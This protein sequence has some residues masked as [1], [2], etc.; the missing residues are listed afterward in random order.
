MRKVYTSEGALQHSEKRILYP[1][2]SDKNLYPILS[3]LLQ[4]LRNR[5]HLSFDW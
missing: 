1:I 4:I 5:G 2:I 3:A